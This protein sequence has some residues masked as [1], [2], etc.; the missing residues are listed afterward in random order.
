M[1][2]QQKAEYKPKK[3]E[4]ALP[5][6]APV[7]TFYVYR[8][9]APPN[10]ETDY[11]IA[12]VNVASL[13]GVMWYL[14]DE[15][16]GTCA[17]NGA[18]KFGITRI[19]RFKITTKATT[20]LWKKEMNFGLKCSFDSGECT[21]P[22]FDHVEGR[23]TGAHIMHDIDRYGFYVGCN[24]LGEWPHNEKIFQRARNYPNAIWYSLPGPC[25]TTNFHRATAECKASQ[26]G[27]LCDHPD[28][29]GNCTYSIEE[30]GEI[31][32][33]ELVGITP[34]WKNR[35]EFCRSGGYEGRGS[36]QINGRNHHWW[37]RIWDAKADHERT[38]QAEAM[39]KKKYPNAPDLPPP[40]CDV[41][42]GKFYR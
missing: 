22:H 32:I 13:G 25:P 19:R 30:A 4:L 1:S 17:R 16:I 38:A 11:P 6:D 36:G 18:R 2:P 37:D 41:K 20:P 40:P 12:N 8:A 23:G 35:G 34:K 15:V 26:P 42:A 3:A 5:S 27:G 7:H 29:R 10:P 9:Q 31:D 33:D 24:N 14:H 39:F 21:G 28:G